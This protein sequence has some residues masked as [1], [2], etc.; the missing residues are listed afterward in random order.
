MS[1]RFRRHFTITGSEGIPHARVRTVIIPGASQGGPTELSGSFLD[2]LIAVER[3]GLNTV[4]VAAVPADLDTAPATVCRYVVTSDP[5][6]AAEARARYGTERVVRTRSLDAWHVHDWVARLP[7]PE[8]HTLRR[9]VRRTV[10]AL[11]LAEA[12]YLRLMSGTWSRRN[13]R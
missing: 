1:V 3:A 2:Q 4:L 7:A 11:P 6:V 9:K 10:Q 12:A 5:H 8:A 13:G